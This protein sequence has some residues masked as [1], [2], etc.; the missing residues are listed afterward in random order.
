MS[1]ID[2]HSHILPNID[3]G[4][5]SVQ[6]SYN[7][8]K[9]MAEESV[10]VAFATPHF[11]FYIEDENVFIKKRTEAYE[12][13]QS[14]MEKMGD[15]ADLPEIRMGA[16]IRVRKTMPKFSRYEELSLEGTGMM[17]FELPYD[18]YSAYYGENIHNISHE[19]G[20]IPV[21]A[22]I[23]RYLDIYSPGDFDELFSIPDVVLQITTDF[24]ESRKT[25]HFVAD[26]IN[27]EFPVLFGSD[28]H[29]MTSRPPCMSK[30]L[31]NL[32]KFCSK[33]KVP[34]NRIKD[35]FNY[36]CSLV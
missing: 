14:Y 6:T 33:Y 16:E 17:L 3:D 9:K 13:L 10:D 1:Y 5:D 19:Y 30:V 18:K 12:K 27:E 20:Y 36:H 34:A 15:T 23:E 8:L 4:S 22:H 29:N 25:A 26:I 7:M 28:C 24:T 21:I 31:D 32:K 11:R 35:L 2:F